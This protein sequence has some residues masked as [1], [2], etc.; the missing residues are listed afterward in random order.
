MR[1]SIGGALD[2]GS[3]LVPDA[4]WRRTLSLSVAAGPPICIWALSAIGAPASSAIHHL[5]FISASARNRGSNRSRRG[6]GHVHRR[7]FALSHAYTAPGRSRLILDGD[8]K[9]RERSG[10]QHGPWPLTVRLCCVQNDFCEAAD[11]RCGCRRESLY[12]RWRVSGDG[13]FR[14]SRQHVRAHGRAACRLHRTM[15]GSAACV[16]G[17]ISRMRAACGA[18]GRRQAN[19]QGQNRR[20]AND[21]AHGVILR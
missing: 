5:Y 15:C 7:I 16:C 8:G 17:F 6:R 14:S 1:I 12:A 13:I 18:W 10:A 4:L 21:E 20:E 2:S 11:F 9:R 19:R 3:R